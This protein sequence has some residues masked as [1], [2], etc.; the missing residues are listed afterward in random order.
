MEERLESLL[1][2]GDEASL[3]RLRDD[4]R[5]I[6][7]ELSMSE[8]FRTLDELIGAFLGTR[9]AKLETSLAQARNRGMPYDPERLALFQ[10][11]FEELRGRGP[12]TRPAGNMADSAR[13]NLAFFEAYFS[14]YIE[15]TEFAIDE[16]V[17]I[18]FKGV[19]PRERPEDAHDILGTF[20]IVSD[21]KQM[22][23]TPRG[24]ES[25]VS[26]LKQRHG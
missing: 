11:L 1:R 10:K 20:R 21:D 14:N 13:T 3:N 15:G 23:R 16:A 18:V 5:A 25:L 26:L 24:F 19:I 4:A 9:E 22:A 7:R 17:D 8:E 2:Q 6:S 12:V